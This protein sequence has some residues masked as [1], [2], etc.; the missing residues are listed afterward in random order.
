MTQMESSGTL[1]PNSLKKFNNEVRTYFQKGKVI[2][3]EGMKAKKQA[4][5]YSAFLKKNSAPFPQINSFNTNF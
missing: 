4:C 1:T 5:R 3:S 2:F